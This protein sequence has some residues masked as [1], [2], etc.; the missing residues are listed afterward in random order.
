M[1]AAALFDR[2]TRFLLCS[3][4]PAATGLPFTDA[5]VRWDRCTGAAACLSAIECRQVDAVV[6][7]AHGDHAWTIQLLTAAHSL[8]RDGRVRLFAWAPAGVWEH[9]AMYQ[10]GAAELLEGDPV[11]ADQVLRVWARLKRN[12]PA[13]AAS[14]HLLCHGDLTL[15][16]ER[17]RAARNGRTI[18]LSTF[19]VELLA[20]LIRRPHDV[21]TREELAATI[22]AGR[23]LNMANVRTC[24]RRLRHALNGPGERELIRNVRDRGYVLD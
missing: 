8:A 10:A 16:P 3:D 4:D 22:W 19:Q 24:F 17:F 6:I 2:P 7:A 21:F 13:T 1:A 9:K 18:R 11:P 5:N 14:P 12:R 23:P 20:A 15:D